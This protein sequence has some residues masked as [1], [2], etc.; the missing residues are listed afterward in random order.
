M[1]RRKLFFFFDKISI[2]ERTLNG[3]QRIVEERG[4]RGKEEKVC[5]GV[6]RSVRITQAETN[7]S[8]VRE[9]AMVKTLQEDK[10]TGF[11]NTRASNSISI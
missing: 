6:D 5:C 8:T 11:R 7:E 10:W 1:V 2:A 3:W 4:F 9:G